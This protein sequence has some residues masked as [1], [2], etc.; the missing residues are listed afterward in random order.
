M[1]D[2]STLGDRMKRQEAAYRSVLPRR[3]YTIIRVDG[4][5]FHSYLRG[6]RRPYDD[7]FMAD[8]DAV[9]RALCEEV[10]GSAFAYTQSDEISV[11]VSDFATPQTQA[12]FGGTI[13]KQVSITAAL[14]TA[15]LNERRPFG[16]RALFD[17]RVFTLADPVEVASY[18]LWRQQ[19]AVRNSIAMT[20]QAHFSHH[21]LH[22]LSTGEMQEL[23]FTEADVN[24]N[25][26]P[27]GFK[28]GRVAV[29]VS[30]ERET[31]Y[32]DR[33]TDTEH[34]VTALRS[35]WESSPAQHFTTAPNDWLAAHIP[36]LPTLRP[37]AAQ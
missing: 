23:L 25:E 13:A 5:A 27:D 16:R 3:T 18:F 37:Q 4:R 24:W 2:H 30:G 1:T 17:S 35:W 22:G 29:R 36:P 31:T 34:T 20:A 14:A 32:T 15:V 12:W 33:R 9:A 21:R 10:T 11:L 26:Q 7:G 19:D 6:A 28:R 8:M